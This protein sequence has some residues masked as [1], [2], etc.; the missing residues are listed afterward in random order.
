MLVL[1]GSCEEEEVGLI[2]VEWGKRRNRII[3]IE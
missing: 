1:K 3:L 2:G